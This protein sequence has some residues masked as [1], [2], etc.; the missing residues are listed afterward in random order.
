MPR[1]PT[2]TNVTSTATDGAYN[3]SDSPVFPIT[4]TF[5]KPVIVTG[6]PPLTLATGSPATTA[7]TYTSG[8]GTDTL[9][10]T[11]TAARRTTRRT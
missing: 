5:S 8:S 9:T 4:V 10:F 2:V 11:Y 1:A 6:T 3:A 7:V